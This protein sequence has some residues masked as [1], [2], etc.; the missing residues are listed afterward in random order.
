MSTA[1]NA[2][3]SAGGGLRSPLT[4]EAA[5]RLALGLG[6][7]LLCEG[8]IVGIGNRLT[9]NATLI[10]AASGRTIGSP[11]RAVASVD[12]IETLLNQVATTL[13]GTGARDR[14]TDAVRLTKSP[15]ALRSYFEGLT[16]WRRGD[17]RSEAAAAFEA[18]FAADTTFALAAYQRWLIAQ[19][20][21]GSPEWG[22]RT[23]ALR[24]RLPTRERIVVDGVFGATDAPRTPA[25]RNADLRRAAERLGDSPEA[26]YLYGDDVYHSRMPVTD[27]DSLIPIAQAA[28]QR[29]AADSQS[30]SMGHLL[31]IAM[32]TR[33]TAL[34]RQLGRAFSRFDGED[35]W[36][37]EWTAAAAL[38]D[39]TQ[40]N[41][42]RQ[43]G[44]SHQS[45]EF[46]GLA[47]ISLLDTPAP[48]ALV[49]EGF[50]RLNAVARDIERR[51]LVG[52]VWLIHRARAQPTAAEQATRATDF[53][54]WTFSVA[55]SGWV[56]FS[57]EADDTAFI[58]RHGTSPLAD[59]AAEG[60][61]LCVA[62]RLELQLGRS[63]SVELPANRLPQRCARVLEIWRSFVANTVTPAEVAQ[64]DSI[65]SNV[66]I[67]GFMG[68]E[69]RLLSR[70]YETRGDTA[71]A[72]R[73]IKLYP[74]DFPGVWLAPTYRDLGRA[75]LIARDSANALRWWNR[76]LEL[77]TEPEPPYVA[78]R[79]SIRALIATIAGRR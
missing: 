48:M 2:W 39:A 58:R 14:S 61:R 60:R 6:A 22:A 32:S 18:A 36:A 49:L 13:L 67:V 64:L 73:A 78:E 62:A 43:R 19:L 7:G 74:R 26:W 63:R 40:L 47:L 59:A 55:G 8:S 17:R 15:A 30:I 54:P 45:T 34:Y 35:S 27:P 44:P 10:D 38:R 79:D 50:R 72:L 12:S 29:A 5:R 21:A 20:L 16:L 31:S 70:I 75:Y 24:E 71:R 65:A 33:D 11:A 9:V 52:T 51:R 66:T 77:R 23:R 53:S 1:L 69:H 68:F 76:F 25:Q 37:R 3:R 56:H 41:R 42:L 28:F 4:Q 57:G 46:S